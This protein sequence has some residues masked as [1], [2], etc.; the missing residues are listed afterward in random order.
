M[1]LDVWHVW[2]SSDLFFL[3]C[4]GHTDL[5]DSTKVTALDDQN[6]GPHYAR[7]CPTPLDPAYL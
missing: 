7:R 3:D 6:A 4:D 2:S 1:A 5:Q